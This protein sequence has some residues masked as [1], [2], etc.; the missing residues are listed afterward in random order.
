MRRV[1]GVD[2]DAEA[3]HVFGNAAPGT[4][5]LHDADGACYR[6]AATAKTLGT[7]YRRFIQE[8]L[9]DKFCTGAEY[10]QAHITLAGSRKADRPLYPTALPYQANRNGKSKP[11]LLEPLR[12]LLASGAEPLPDG[13]ELVAHR[14]WEADDGV[15]M[16]SYRQGSTGV[17]KSEDKDLRMTPHPYYDSSTGKIDII[18]D[19]FGWIDEAYTE[20]MKL[21]VQGHGT[22]FF[23]AQMLAGD[24]AD[25]IRGLERYRGR[26]V[27][28][29][30]ALEFLQG[31]DDENEAANRV[32]W[33]Y[34]RSGQDALAEAE[35]LWLRRD[36]QDSAFAYIMELELNAALNKW[37]R[38]LHDYHKQVLA[39]AQEARKHSEYEETF[40]GG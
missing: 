1:L 21:K 28:E 34:A 9:A 29:A 31:I 33:E 39:A 13:M 40:H 17:V 2:L 16:E 32:L 5:L 18:S 3:P 35:V 37:V 30:G 23:W 15:V 8:V 22:K 10:V 19:H 20:G 26:R 27:A 24:R 36:E 12:A 11:P 7:V 6:A 38:E 14:Y 4:V 25:N